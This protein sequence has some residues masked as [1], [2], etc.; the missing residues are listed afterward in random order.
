MASAFRVE[1]FLLP[2]LCKRVISD[3]D[4]RLRKIDTRVIV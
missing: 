3:H 4:C 2:T 1:L